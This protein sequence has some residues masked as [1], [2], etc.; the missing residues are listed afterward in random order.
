MPNK[1]TKITVVS[2]FTSKNFGDCAQSVKIGRAKATPIERVN[3]D[4]LG[5]AE[6]TAKDKALV[7]NW[8]RQTLKGAEYNRYKADKVGWSQEVKAKL[9]KK[10]NRLRA[11]IEALTGEAMAVTKAVAKPKTKTKPKGSKVSAELAETLAG[12]SPELQSAFL[13][14]MK[15]QK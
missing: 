15:A 12:L 6:Y 8:A 5:K 1:Q 3:K 14:M 9:S 7:V 4:E 13:A 2:T 11:L 10:I